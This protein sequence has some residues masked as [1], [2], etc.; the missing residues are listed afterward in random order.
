MKKF[1]PIWLQSFVNV[2]ESWKWIY[3][4]KTKIIYD[5]I[6]AWLDW[7]NRY[8]LSRPRRFG[9][10]LLIDTIR[11]LYEWKKELFEWLFIY[12]RWD[13]KNKKHPVLKIVFWNGF[14][15]DKK[16]LNTSLMDLF[17]S[18]ENEFDLKLKSES[19]EWKFAELITRLYQ[20]TGKKVV[21]LVDEY[22]KPILDQIEKLEKAQDIRDALKWFYSVIKW[23]DEYIEFVL[24]TWVTKFSK[25]SLFSWLNNL[26]DLTLNKISWEICGFTHTE[27]IENFWKEWYLEDIDLSE[28][29]R[30]Y[31]GFN[32]LWENTVYN[33]FD[34]LL[35]LKNKKYEAYWFE[36]ATPTFLITLLKTKFNF[37]SIPNLENINVWKEIM[38]S[39]DIEKINIETLLFQTGYLTIK[40]EIEE[41]WNIIYR[42]WIPNEEIA[43]SFNTYIISDYLEAF[44]KVE[45]F[46]R[47]KPIYHSLKDKK[48]EDFI[49]AWKILFANIPYS[50]A[51]HLSKYEWYYA[52]VMFSLFYSMGLRIVNEDITNLWRID[53]TIIFE[54]VIYILEFK[55]IEKKKEYWS[56]LKQIQDKKYSEKY[57]WENKQIIELWIEFSPKSKNIVNFEYKILS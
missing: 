32:F 31:N 1:L 26:E 25:V 43:R 50:N 16:Y 52:S 39:F 57:L 20:K 3:V 15:E 37:Y 24:I 6:N 51:N 53:L 8:F 12:S 17:L 48:V 28:M 36:S 33:P 23:A 55:V 22:D 41:F 35:F 14:V 27:I 45:Y 30:W 29:K 13:W 34:I 10:S 9:K 19:I 40:E 4:D 49:E 11:C 42:L 56:A 18:F 47:A 46:K 21:I 2:V 54:D 38:W 7:K 44:E 5:L